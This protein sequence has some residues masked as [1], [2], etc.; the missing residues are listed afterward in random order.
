MLLPTWMACFLQN[1]QVK[2]G[3]Y[4]QYMDCLGYT[5]LQVKL[6]V[7]TN[8]V[9]DAWRQEL[10]QSYKIHKRFGWLVTR[11]EINVHSLKYCWWKKS[12]TSWYGEYPIIYRFFSHSRWC[13]I[14]SINSTVDGWWSSSQMEIITC[15]IL[16]YNPSLRCHMS[17]H[18]PR[19]HQGSS[20][21]EL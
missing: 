15:H 19:D 6:E 5:Y 8:F 3:K 4:M 10:C 9:K 20:G 1:M 11:I 18:E 7:A 12:C 16:T 14:S 17:S 2:N 21:F 13:R